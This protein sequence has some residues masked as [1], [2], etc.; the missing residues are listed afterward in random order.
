M[1]LFEKSKIVVKLAWPKL[2]HVNTNTE[3][4]GKQKLVAH[5]NKGIGQCEVR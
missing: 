3:I 1:C 5:K 2:T 4:L